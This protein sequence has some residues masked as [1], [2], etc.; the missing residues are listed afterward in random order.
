MS[1]VGACLYNAVV[2]RFFS[3]LKNEWLLN[4]AH[5]TRD[6][7]KMDTEEYIHYDKHEPLHTTLG[8][9]TPINN[10]KLQSQVPVQA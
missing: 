2:E 4:I 7:I 1:S 3:S 8:A 5:L 6:A 10:E 9:L